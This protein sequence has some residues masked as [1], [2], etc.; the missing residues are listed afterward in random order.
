MKYFDYIFISGYR[1]YQKK[2]SAPRGS[3]VY[4]VLALLVGY[5]F[6]FAAVSK[7]IWGIT[8]YLDFLGHH[9]ML[10]IVVGVI[11]IFLINYYYSSTRTQKLN[12]EFENLS[13]STR[14]LWGWI[15]VLSIII[16]YSVG[17]YFAITT[18]PRLLGA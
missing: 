2:E 13:L 5:F 4:L 15:T 11:L 1:A 17:L 18:S 14:K 6:L 12:D 10:I 3:G 9:P 7:R 8:P 16:P